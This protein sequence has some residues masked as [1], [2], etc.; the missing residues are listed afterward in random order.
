MSLLLYLGFAY[1]PQPNETSLS[2]AALSSRN[3][4]SSFQKCFLPMLMKVFPGGSEIKKLPAVQE[5]RVH[6]WVRKIPWRRNRLP[7]PLFLPGKSHGQRSL[8]GYSPRGHKQSD[9]TERLSSSGRLVKNE[10]GQ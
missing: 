2:K 6:S 5:P 7:T 4:L 10:K 3:F 9:T 1:V 8:V